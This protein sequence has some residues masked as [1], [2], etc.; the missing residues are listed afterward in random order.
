MYRNHSLRLT[1]PAADEMAFG[2]VIAEPHEEIAGLLLEG[3]ARALQEAGCLEHN[4]Q[5]RYVPS[6][7]DLPMAT[8]FL[9]EYTDVDAVILL[10]CAISDDPTTPLLPTLLQQTLS[11][12]MHWNMPCAWGVIEGKSPQALLEQRNRAVETA[13][14]AIRMVRM[15]MDMEAQAPNASP[16]DRRL[17]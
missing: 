10:G 9:A 15:Q 14:E 16:T 7:C 2:I 5:I 12:Q 8:Q 4:I 3:A 11:I 1:L 17:N 13:A 6:L